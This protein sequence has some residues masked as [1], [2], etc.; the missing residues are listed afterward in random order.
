MLSPVEVAVADKLFQVQQQKWSDDERFSQYYDGR[1]R[2]ATLGLSLPPA[3][4]T[5]EVVVN[6]PRVAVEAIVERSDVKTIRRGGEIAA[7][8]VLLEQFDANNLDAQMVMFNRDK[9][10]YGRA[11]LSVG[12][13]EADPEHPLMMVESPRELSVLVDRRS[14]SLTAALR[15]VR[16]DS[17]VV[18][19][20]FAATLYLPE[21]TIWLE[22]K[23]GKWFEIDRDEHGLGRVPIVM[24]LN[25]QVTGS[26]TGRSEMLD[27]IPIADAAVRTLTNMQYAVEAA[28]VPRKYVVGASQGDFVDASGKALPTW[29]AYLGS[30]WALVNKDA[31]VGQLAGADLS[32]F[33]KT[34]ELYGKMASSVTGYPGSYFGLHTGNPAGEGQIKG[35]EARLVKTVERSNTETGKALAWA[36]DL[37]ERFRTGEWVA[38]NRTVVE[39]HNPGTPTFAQKADALQKLAG[40]RPLISREGVW[41]EL[42]WS[43]AR[44]ERERANFAD[45]ASDPLMSEMLEKWNGVDTA[46]VAG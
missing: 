42:G 46:R 24:A 5:L 12:S 22:K 7:D 9:L 2:L 15:V 36:L 23:Q 14:R 21:V 8:E 31:K 16:G 44:K 40:G 20:V 4:D 11:F 33:H 17:S 3:L 30:V 10:I 43:E 25:R 13:N 1:H 38:G 18:D 27:V 29:E 41:D 32:G 39:H 28:A 45:E 37:S 6:W 34:L 26:W 19:S 35:E